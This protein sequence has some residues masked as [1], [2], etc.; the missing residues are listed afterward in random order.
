MDHQDNQAPITVLQITDTHLGEKPGSS[1]LGLDT[2]SSFIQV[3]ELVTQQC[4]KADWLLAT[5][6]ISN[7]GTVASYQRFQ[8]LSSSLAHQRVWLPGNH[9]DLL[10]MASATDDGPEMRKLIELDHWVIVMLNSAVPGKVG[11]NLSES[12]LQ[13]LEASLEQHSKKHV[14]VCMHHHPIKSGCAWLDY[15]QIA[16]SEALFDII[17]RFSNVKALLWG[18]I[19]QEIDRMEGDIRLLATPS[20]CIQFAPNSEDFKLDRNTPGYRWLEL[21]PDGRLETSVSR[22]PIESIANIDYHSVE[23]Y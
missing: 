6:D 15:Q 7:D 4:G 14:L 16:N 22:L 18:H 20:S 17:H 9:D 1:L 8:E 13:F 21:Y 19:H 5:G 11:G 23:G 12:E 10:N 3:H 2:D